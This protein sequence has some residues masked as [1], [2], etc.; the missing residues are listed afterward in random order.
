VTLHAVCRYADASC[1]W[2]SEV[3]ADEGAY[4]GRG[5]LRRVAIVVEAVAG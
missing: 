1:G 2:L 4:H 5:L 3:E